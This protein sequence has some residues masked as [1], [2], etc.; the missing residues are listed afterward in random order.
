MWWNCADTQDWAFTNLLSDFDCFSNDAED[1]ELIYHDP[2]YG[3]NSIRNL[4]LWIRSAL[5]DVDAQNILQ[6][7]FWSGEDDTLNGVEF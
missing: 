4:R 5:G 6:F 1:C 2:Q 3:M 7:H